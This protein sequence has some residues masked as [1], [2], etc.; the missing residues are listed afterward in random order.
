MD[1]IRGIENIPTQLHC[2]VVTIGNFDGIHLGHRLIIHKLVEEARREGCPAIVISFDPHPKM[3]IHPER[4]PFYLITPIE[5]K[6]RLLE[7]L[8]VDAF[9][10][11]PFSLEY[12]RTTAEE[13]IRGLLVERLRI[14]KIIIGHDT[15]F[16]RA[17][18]GNEAF[19]RE[20]GKRLGFGVEVMNAVRVGDTTVSSTRIRE[21]LLA[22][23]VRLAASLLGRPYNLGGRVVPGYRRGVRLGFPTANI[24]PDKELVPARGVYAV[25]VILGGT[26]YQGAL[27][28][29][30]NPTF[31]D[32]KRS[33]EVHILD[34]HEDIY[35]K[36]LD[37]F[38]IERLRDE[39]RFA[40]PE[41]LI[42]QIDRD[43]AQ[44]RE[45]LQAEQ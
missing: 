6:T 27:S 20:F 23:D 30:I 11:I 26:R 38:F 8:G 45:I 34:F 39:I 44:V 1:V 33:I 18:E 42:A 35:D 3:V 15:T 2:A 28:I 24:I 32:Q 10:L 4:R 31:T 41:E 37:M 29:G 19:L 9:L 16:G 21:A 25:R 12:A 43:I 36:T 22:G 7:T 17:M 40:S 13:F 5:E 14:Q